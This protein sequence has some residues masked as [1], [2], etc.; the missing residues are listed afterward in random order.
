MGFCTPRP[1]PLTR[2]ISHNEFMSASHCTYVWVGSDSISQEQQP[3]ADPHE[4]DFA[5]AAAGLASLLLQLW[6]C[7]FWVVIYG[8]GSA[9]KGKKGKKKQKVEP[10]D[11]IPDDSDSGEDSDTEEWIMHQPSKSTRHQTSAP[12]DKPGKA[13]KSKV[14]KG[15][16]SGLP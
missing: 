4:H 15:K 1:H 9:G 3:D 11:D 5:P 12:T 7:D 16:K 14:Q 13:K 8:I 2:H 10:W 6:F